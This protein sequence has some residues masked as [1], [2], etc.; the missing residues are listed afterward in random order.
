MVL[1]DPHLLNFYGTSF[2]IWLFR[3]KN[4]A[5]KYDFI[6]KYHRDKV[7]FLI[8]NRDT[9]LYLPGSFR[10]SKI[11]SFLIKKLFF[12]ID[13]FFWKKINNVGNC[14]IVYDLVSLTENDF[15]FTFIFDI[16]SD[17][18]FYAQAS[19]KHLMLV[20]VSHIAL[21]TRR[22]I[23]NLKTI[24]N[25]VLVSEISLKSNK[26][27]TN[28]IDKKYINDYLMPFVYQN[29]FSEKNKF[30]ERINTCLAIG[31]VHRV[32][33]GVGEDFRKFYGESYF[34]PLRYEIMLNEHNYSSLIQS[35]IIDTTPN[36]VKG[37]FS[38]KL[39]EYIR[40]LFRSDEDYFRMDLNEEFNKYTM[41]VCPEELIRVPSINFVYGMASGA[42]YIGQKSS[43]YSDIGLIADVHYISYDG[44][45]SGLLDRV[46]FYQ[47]DK[48]F[49]KL[50]KIASNGRE[51][52]IKEF[53]HEKVI[54][55]L[56]KF[57]QNQKIQL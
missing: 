21:N 7:V 41:F 14:E 17:K 43:M 30:I 22:M 34:H 8:K 55:D 48:N 11:G 28:F 29:R 44:T 3:K 42:A 16:D 45:L 9:T 47:K 1:V 35:K 37:G 24:K 4:N 38:V 54:G 39:L 46:K 33:S 23:D 27:V 6:L 49:I 5:R 56:F 53:N 13:L 51:F 31:T 52:V 20:N 32:S 19:K 26:Y 50:Q 25:K 12:K 10:R 15:F 18:S 40:V 57:V 2:F 36:L